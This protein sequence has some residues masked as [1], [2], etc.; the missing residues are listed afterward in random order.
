MHLISDTILNAPLSRRTLS[1]TALA[2]TLSA[3]GGGGGSSPAPTQP[4]S[5]APVLPKIT[6]QPESVSVPAGETATFRVVVQSESPLSYQWLRSGTPIAGATTAELSLPFVTA[7][8]SGNAFSVQVSNA[9][10]AVQSDAATLWVQSVEGIALASGALG[11]LSADQKAVGFSRS[12]DIFV[13]ELS[14]PRENNPM[15]L[16]RL[17]RDGIKRPLLGSKQ[18]LEL[19]SA[20]RVSVLEHSNG[21]LYISESYLIVSGLNVWR[22]N[23]G[24]IH[25]ITPDGTH[26]VI[27]DSKTATAPLESITPVVLVEGPNARIYALHMNTVTLYEISETGTPSSIA[28]LTNTP[29]ENLGIIFSRPYLNMVA[30]QAGDIFVST[31]GENF[32]KPLYQPFDNG[33]VTGLGA[34]G[35]HLYALVDDENRYMSL[36][37]RN[38]DGSTQRI[39]GGIAAPESGNPQPGPLSGSLG[40]YAIRLAGVTPEG[41]IILGRLASDRYSGMEDFRYDQYF[42]VT[43]PPV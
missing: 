11:K 17:S 36:I 39:A 15:F 5:P 2:A 8:D 32:I 25:R 7:A 9:A 42:V 33:T 29:I 19:A 10:G 12:G 34:I 26:S 21:N 6:T 23:G 40:G 37:R 38:P 22:G 4:E 41:N 16:T 14:A 28:S 3:C 1:L 27:Y 20:W 30:T 24:R 35:N 31:S 43:P 18:T 13:W